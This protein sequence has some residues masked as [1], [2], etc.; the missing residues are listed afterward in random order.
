M[1]FRRCCSV[2]SSPHTW[3]TLQA[4]PMAHSHALCCWP[5]VPRCPLSNI[6]Q[7]RHFRRLA[8]LAVQAAQPSQIDVHE[9]NTQLDP[10]DTFVNSASAPSVPKVSRN[11]LSSRGPVEPAR[12]PLGPTSYTEDKF[13]PKEELWKALVSAGT[14]QMEE[15]VASFSSAVQQAAVR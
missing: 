5:Q 9:S 14:Q 11:S 15:R 10:S 4:K 7:Q 2:D 8:K 13:N 6:Q 12:R 3:E 1:E